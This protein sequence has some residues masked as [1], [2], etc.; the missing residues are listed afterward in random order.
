MKPRFLPLL[1]L[2]PLGLVQCVAPYP[3]GGGSQPYN[4]AREGYR[5]EAN[6]YQRDQSGQAY[7]AGQRDGAS[8]AAGGMQRNSYRNQGR[9]APAAAAAYRDGY[10]R[11]YAAES[12]NRPP[13]QQPPP[14][15]YGNGGGG[16]YP[17]PQQSG[18]GNPAPQPQPQR[19]PT[20]NQG[21]DY[22]LRDRVGQRPQ[23]PDA[24]TGSYDPRFRQSFQRGY[25]DG[26]ESRR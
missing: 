22:G 26:Y 18:Y 19:D 15:V 9:F 6:E 25:A 20:Y 14:P 24:H 2:F 10:E 1:C 11:G 17:Y 5:T 23:D 13:P 4:E 8:D 3:Y 16:S 21:Y 7:E 12:S